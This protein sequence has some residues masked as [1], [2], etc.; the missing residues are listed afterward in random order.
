MEGRKLI[1]REDWKQDCLHWQGR[2][3]TGEKAHWCMDWD[4]LPIDETCP[5]IDCC[6]CFP[7]PER[8]THE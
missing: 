8:T 2:V 3:L 6:N 4:C 7:H 5:E 1:E